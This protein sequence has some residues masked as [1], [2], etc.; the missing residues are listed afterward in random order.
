MSDRWLAGDRRRTTRGTAQK[1]AEIIRR[2]VAWKA[3]S[4]QRRIRN[5]LISSTA[6][7]SPHVHQAGMQTSTFCCCCGE[8]RKRSITSLWIQPAQAVSP[9]G[10]D[11]PFVLACCLK[12]AAAAAALWDGGGGASRCSAYPR[13]AAQPNSAHEHATR[14]ESL[15]HR[16]PRRRQGTPK[17]PW[18]NHAE[19]Q[20]AAR[21]ADPTSPHACQV[22]GVPDA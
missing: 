13:Q 21:A 16:A 4:S 22:R 14:A 17:R 7:A 2:R 9:H 10:D 5:S 18:C 11:R 19:A 15:Q 6:I 1:E 20:A 12:A 3:R 8:I